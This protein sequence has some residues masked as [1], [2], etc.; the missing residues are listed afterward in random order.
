MN[1]VRYV[2]DESILDLKCDISATGV[3]CNGRYDYSIGKKLS[4]GSKT[5]NKKIEECCSKYTVKDLLGKALVVSDNSS[6]K[7]FAALFIEGIAESYRQDIN[8]EALYRALT[9]VY[10]YAKVNK[11]NTIALPYKMGC[12][13]TSNLNWFD[14][15]QIIYDLFEHTPDIEIKIYYK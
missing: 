4:R 6:H 8:V 1:I 15:E 5:F 3:S 10:N 14:M 9:Q 12:T 13:K 2:E 7:V 11:L